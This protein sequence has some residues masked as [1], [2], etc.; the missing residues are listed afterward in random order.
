[1]SSLNFN[2]VSSTSVISLFTEKRHL[3][4]DLDGTL[5]DSAPDLSSAIN[6][7]LQAL[8]L[9]TF[10][11]DVIRGWVGNGAQVL[12]HRALSGSSELDTNINNERL[13]RALKIFLK[14]YESQLCVD[15]CLYPNVKET[16]FELKRRGYSLSIVTNKPERFVAPILAQLGIGDLFELIIGGDTLEKRKPDPLP[17]FHACRALN[18][19]PEQVVMIG[20]SKND[21]LAAKAANMLSIGLTYGYNYGESI[22]RYEPEWVCED[23][24]QLLSVFE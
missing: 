12:T 20:D 16:L 6:R 2:T 7:M 23:F 3:L 18:L 19:A 1:M 22:A 8:S 9:N 5:V 11:P 21:I 4:F 10:S 15:S 24:A 13:N 14:E 17:L